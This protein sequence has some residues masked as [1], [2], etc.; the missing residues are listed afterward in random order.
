M[1]RITKSTIGAKEKHSKAGDSVSKKARREEAR[2]K[3]KQ[4]K[5]KKI[6]II[7]VCASLVVVVISLFVFNALQKK[8]D[9]VFSDGLQTVTLRANGKFTAALAHDSRAGT[10][11]ET[12]ENGVTT[13]SFT[14]EGATV[15]GDITDDVLTIPEEWGDSHGHGSK[16]KLK[17]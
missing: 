9:R 14:A 6:I 16:L 1:E 5:R 17:K 10:Y 3:E 8:G 4:K 12:K 11:T 7:T 13:I 2:K 15:T